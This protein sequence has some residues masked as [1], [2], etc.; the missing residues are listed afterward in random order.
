MPTIR[1]SPQKGAGWSELDLRVDGSCGASSNELLFT[2]LLERV[3]HWA[4]RLEQEI[5]G[6]MRIF[7]G[8]QQLREVTVLEW[9]LVG[10]DGE[11]SGFS[12]GINCLPFQDLVM[13][14]ESS[15]MQAVTFAS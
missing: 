12:G 2:S 13:A 3:Q 9:Y 15:D 5:D 14:L 7:G 6:V 10:S 8:V 1:V 4:R 11:M